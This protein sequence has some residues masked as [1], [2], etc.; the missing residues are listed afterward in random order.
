MISGPQTGESWY[1]P[2]RQIDSLGSTVERPGSLA[3]LAAAR[4]AHKGQFWTPNE[5]ASLMWRIVAPAMEVLKRDR[6]EW[7][8]AIFDNS[9]GSG[10]LLQFADPDVH[11]LF[12]VD[13]DE[14]TLTELGKV[15]QAAGFSC[16]FHVCSMD[17]VL[18]HSM[19]V[20]LI[21]PPFSVHLQSPL[22]DPYPCTTYA[23]F[24]PNT[25]TVSHAY[26]LA[27]AVESAS[28]VV[29]LLPATFAE[30]VFANPERFVPEAHATL[31]AIIELPPGVFKEEGTDVR[32]SILLFHGN[33]DPAT[34]RRIK[35]T[36]LDDALPD[37]GVVL[38]GGRATL[39]VRT[40]ENGGPSIT[41]PVTG[42]VTVRVT[43]D[44]RR[45][46]LHFQC[47]LTQAKVMNSVLRSRVLD[48]GPIEHRRPKGFLYSGQGVLDVEVHLAQDDA[49]ASFQ[50]FLTTIE[51]AGGRPVVAP[52]LWEYLRRRIRQTARQRMPVRHCV[53]VPHGVAAD[54][55]A[56]VTGRARK[57]HTADPAV[58]GSPAITL[59]QELTFHREGDKG[60]RFEI[61]GQQFA[62]SS[63]DLYRRFEVSSGIATSGW[64]VVHEGLP[65]AYPE[66]YN[67]YV[68]RA[69]SLGIDKW[70]TWG[71]QYHDLLE[72]VMKPAG[73]IVAFDMG[74][75]KT[76]LAIALILLVGCKH[77]LIV[78]ESGLIEEMLIELK[79]LPIPAADWQVI[80][81]PE[82]ID[83][84]HRIN[85]ISYERLR[86][87][88]CRGE[89]YGSR[90]RRRIGVI[91]V[92]EGDALAN[93]RSDQ[94]RAV[95]QVSAKRRYVLTGTPQ[96]NYPRSI[97]PLMVFACGDGT[98]AQPWGWYR[99]Y[100]EQN[101][102]QSVSYAERG[103]DAFRNT[104]VSLDWITHEFAD[105]LSTG[106]KREVPRIRNVEK[107]RAMLAP[108]VKRRLDSEPEVTRWVQIPQADREVVEIPWDMGHLDFYLRVAEDF[109]SW[110][111]EARKDLGRHVNLIAILARIRAVSFALDYPQRGIPGFGA[112]LPL[113]SKQRWIIDELERETQEKNKTILYV[114]YPGLLKVISKELNAR[115]IDN[116]LFHGQL[117]IKKR[118][119][120]LNQR[121]R[122]GDCPILLA[123]LGVTQKGLNLPQANRETL[124]SRSWSA[125]EEEQAIKR[126][127]RP[128]Q[129]RKVLVRYAHLPGSLDEYKAQLVRFKQDTVRVGLD[130]ATP[131]ME[132]VEFLHL[133]TVLNR[134]CE[135]LAGLRNINRQDL[136]EYLAK[137]KKEAA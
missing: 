78:T 90:L 50:A 121:F 77:G 80:R 111:R 61:R 2:L 4:R 21:N 38:Y 20:A 74:L 9:V 23:K 48:D 117:P 91:V 116:M 134:F 7:R 118:T 97:L 22:L 57:P 89:T 47:G 87:R 19:D 33:G 45:M 27:Q 1:D 85:I 129:K 98:A 28:A 46:G 5:V 125:T 136:R 32:V 131:E 24:G 54:N 73:E 113:T 60:Y 16:D 76:R 41:L 84:L 25:A 114:E 126:A 135:E 18:A 35:L 70:L 99:G 69:R 100:L 62:I 44:S 120:E 42:D 119:Q 67:S 110:Y 11:S 56:V 95:W 17:A 72:A 109:A 86:M 26:A 104:F 3:G 55:A 133:D 132:E 59:G 40:V 92:D 94:S 34:R 128:Q 107:Y 71:F 66:L 29:A 68:A 13:V 6:P 64:T 130:W 52:G 103:I 31:D 58:W 106:A 83:S 8:I 101:W 65:A 96:R 88:A 10:R 93:P 63:E 123:S 105:S 43:H 115:G 15:A 49:M 75:G 108:H 122:N 137:T 82:Q 81:S 30:E 51:E 39:R 37:F 36:T 112:Y 53:Y 102:R 127:L 124:G 79:P 14:G 12:G